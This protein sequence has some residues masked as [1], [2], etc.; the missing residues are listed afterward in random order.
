MPF[1]IS[2]PFKASFTLGWLRKNPGWKPGLHGKGS[3]GKSL[4]PFPRLT[5]CSNEAISLFCKTSAPDTLS[6]YPASLSNPKKTQASDERL[7][8]P[9]LRLIRT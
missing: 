7:K 4:S 5:G 2:F 9:I 6:A 1:A 8:P 3:A